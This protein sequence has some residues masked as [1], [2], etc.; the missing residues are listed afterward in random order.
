[1]GSVVYYLAGE[2][3]GEAPLVT[4]EAVKS[5]GPWTAWGIPDLVAYG[6]MAVIGLAL[7]ILFATMRVRSARKKALAKRKRIE[8][9][10]IAKEQQ[11]LIENKRKR[12]WP[13]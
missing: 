3:V 8:E 1:V 9:A 2:K 13:Y 7:I 12:D 6:I 11:E 4:A 10:R 5:G